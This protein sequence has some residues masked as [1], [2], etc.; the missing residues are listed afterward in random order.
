MTVRV[1]ELDAQAGPPHA[2]PRVAARV[3]ADAFGAF[4]G[5]LEQKVGSRAVSGEIIQDAFVHG[6]HKH[7]AEHA[8]ESA[9]QWFYRLLR[10]AVIDLPRYAS[11]SETAPTS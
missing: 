10:N 1:A 7:G 11:S 9:G 5:F 2:T 6:T 8:H 4:S 3:L